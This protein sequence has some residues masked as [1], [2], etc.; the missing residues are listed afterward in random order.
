[1]LPQKRT[2]KPSGPPTGSPPYPAPGG[3][4][5]VYDPSR[6]SME[7]EFDKEQARQQ[8]KGRLLGKGI[9]EE[10]KPRPTLEKQIATIDGQRY[11]LQGERETIQGKLRG[12]KITQAEA[13]KAYA[14][15][16]A[17]AIA[18]GNNKAAAK[19][20]AL[21]AGQKE[22]QPPPES[23]ASMY[24]RKLADL[25]NKD[26]ALKKRL[27]KLTGQQVGRKPS[28]GR[29]AEA[30]GPPKP[31]ADEHGFVA[32]KKY[33]SPKTGKTHTYLGSGQFSQA[34]D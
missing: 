26:K 29:S 9:R 15:T 18:A 11:K 27:V 7:L 22:Y 31:A 21:V 6:G 16:L 14:K 17:A 28:S 10:M 24:R 30:L 33:I 25:D 32:G 8:E 12:K 19:D 5:W 3:Y 20:E 13:D 4:V 23:V 2:Q 34:L 1:M